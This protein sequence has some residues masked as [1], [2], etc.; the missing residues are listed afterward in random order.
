MPILVNKTP[1]DDEVI[2]IKLE[3]SAAAQER[4]DLVNRSA[5][6]VKQTSGANHVDLRIL[7]MVTN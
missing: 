3:P 4:G 2:K 6:A 5:R 7:E 1:S